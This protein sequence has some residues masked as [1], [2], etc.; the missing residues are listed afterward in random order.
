MTVFNKST[1]SQ[2][3]PLLLIGLFFTACS[4]QKP[5][6]ST[7]KESPLET[8]SSSGDKL[9][10]LY[11][12][13]PTIL[14][15]HL[16]QGDK[17]LHASRVT[18]EPLASYDKQSKLIPFLAAEIPSLENGGLAKDGKSVTWKLKQGI[19]WSDG[20]SFTAK[21]VVFTYKFISN[22][23]VASTSMAYYETVKNV[24][25]VDDNTV[26]ITFKS[27]NPS[28]SLP[29]VGQNGLILPRHIFEKYNGS[30]VREAPANLAPVGTGP[31]RVV[32]F[33]P[34]DIV[35]YEANP[36]FR[37]ANQLFFKRVELKGGGDAT[38]AARAVLQTGDADFVWNPQ[39]EASI[40]KQL[41]AAGKGKVD[42]VFGGYAER[43]FLNQTDPNKA[44][45]DGER[46]SL[47]FPHPFLSDKKVRQAFNYA[48]DRDTINRQL[49]GATGRATSNTLVGPD[50]Y[51][52]PNTKYEFDLKKAA[53]LLDEAGWK[54]SNG[55]GIRDKN[56][57]E[58]SL[59]F[60]TAVN[61][62]RQK[63]Q[64]IIKQAL[65]SIGV[66]V[67]LK[68]I[69]PSIY[70][71]SDPANPDTVNHFYADIQMFTNGNENPDPGAYMKEWTCDEIPQKKNNWSRRNYSRYC[72]PEY[73]KLWKQSATELN[74]EK[75][76]QLFIQMNDL[77][78]KDA[79]VI[80]LVARAKVNGS[81]NRLA[82]VDVTP[83]DAETWNIKDW[84]R[85]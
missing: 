10:L 55:N 58:M 83:W 61:P 34:G 48:I 33:K 53:A 26:K 43:I 12:Q 46:S 76:R 40:L 9:R 14:N 38:S 23:A 44:T 68:S 54:D 21:D 5:E 31:Y 39:V 13:A 69:D 85:K 50:I 70:F 24:E 84:R 80:P 75:R 8:S 18:Y 72:N 15:S 41:E 19:K 42:T 6:S 51:N 65:T 29:F 59:V 28:W 56:G 4:S 17:D 79:I 67:E 2:I 22:P 64:E 74:P 78:I 77:L 37:D 63:T 27:A 66:K 49:Y 16:S 57:V 73:D 20:Q 25:A 60:Q 32:E 45:K 47:Q 11:W 62:L 81:S 35:I 82:G 30:N 71:S 3:F 1:I 52:S 36:F 7:N